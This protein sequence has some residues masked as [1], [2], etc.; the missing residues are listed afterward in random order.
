M[1]VAVDS[2]ILLAIVLGEP[3]RETFKRLLADVEPVISAATLVEALRTV[4]IRRGA[5]SLARVNALLAAFGFEVVPFGPEDVGLARHGM[6]AYS[7]GRGAEP[8]VLNAGDLFTYALAKRLDA[9]L[10]FKGDDFART[11]V[12]P[13]VR[14]ASG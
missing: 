4:Q 12:T 10:L 13:L 8:A 11:D 1:K 3:E 2:S 5:P 14:P 7:K 9:P 6:V